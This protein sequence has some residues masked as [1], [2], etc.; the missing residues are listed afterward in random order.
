MNYKCN[1]LINCAIAKKR[2]PSSP[3]S[4][5]NLGHHCFYSVSVKVLVK[6]TSFA[7]SY[8]VSHISEQLIVYRNHTADR[9][10]LEVLIAQLISSPTTVQ[11]V[12]GA[13][14][15]ETRNT[16]VTTLTSQHAHAHAPYVYVYVLRTSWSVTATYPPAARCSLTTRSTWSTKANSR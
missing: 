10:F 9:W 4:S 14:C 2:N 15:A 1:E 11:G 6:Y 8:S 7:C 12:A 16:S 13:G 3:K 5:F